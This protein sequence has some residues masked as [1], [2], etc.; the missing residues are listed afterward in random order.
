[1]ID[2]PMIGRL[3][4]PNITGGEGGRTA[5]FGPADWDRIVRHGIQPD[6]HPA[7]MPSE[8]FRSMSDQE[9]SDIIAYV[10]SRPTVDATV[11]PPAP[12]PPCT[13]AG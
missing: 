1:M 5:D 8:D 2:D 7:F 13:R 12:G 10:R 6:G 4:G 3:L 11:P 9:L